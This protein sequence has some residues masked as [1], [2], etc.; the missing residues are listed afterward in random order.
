MVSRLVLFRRSPVKMTNTLFSARAIF[1]N[2]VV[3]YRLP[4][5]MQTDLS[6]A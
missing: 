1:E 2:G 6:S 4:S 5:K 3:V